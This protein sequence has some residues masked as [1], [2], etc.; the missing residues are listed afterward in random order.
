MKEMIMKTAWQIAVFSIVVN[1]VSWTLILL[2][3]L[4][5]LSGMSADMQMIL[6]LYMPSVMIG[7]AYIIFDKKLGLGRRAEP[8]ERFV[9]CFIRCFLWGVI[10][11][12]CIYV[13]IVIGCEGPWFTEGE[14]QGYGMAASVCGGMMW[15]GVGFFMVLCFF[16]RE[17]YYL[18]KKKAR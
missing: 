3:M 2:A 11:F 4:A 16:I 1:V 8:A 6:M 13:A 18:F 5:P 9:E 12:V 10:S 14:A 7:I 17:I 15:V